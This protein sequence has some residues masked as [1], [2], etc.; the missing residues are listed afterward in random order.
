M[1]T[2]SSERRGC[3]GEGFTLIELMVTVAIL[4][5]LA[6]IAYPS[7]TGY[8]QRSRITE[9]TNNMATMRVQL[10]QYY[11]DNRNYGSSATACGNNIG[12]LD[13]DAFSVSC[14]WGAG[15]TDQTYLLTATGKAARG[16][17]GF[18]F[19]L[20]SSNNRQTLAFPGTSGL[21]R[22]C[23]MWRPGDSC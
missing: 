2:N 15:G 21:P 6:A 16:M 20:D 11:Q 3:A 8:I 13:G 12:T 19:T 18:I 4:G 10:E 1:R 7:Y 14:N 17:A 9:A 5:I 22:N 23:W